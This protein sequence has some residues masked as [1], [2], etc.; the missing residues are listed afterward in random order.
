MIHK[1]HNNHR[2]TND[3]SLSVVKYPKDHAA[4]KK[5]YY[6]IQNNSRVT[7]EIKLYE[8]PNKY[9]RY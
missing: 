1:R 6:E 3:G 7:E 8:K 9:E 5:T 4:A 2:V